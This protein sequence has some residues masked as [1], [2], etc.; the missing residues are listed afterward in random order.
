MVHAGR[1]H[2]TMLT[3]LKKPRTQCL[4]FPVGDEPLG[5]KTLGMRLDLE[6]VSWCMVAYCKLR[7]IFLDSPGINQNTSPQRQ[8]AKLTCFRT[9]TPIKILWFGKLKVPAFTARFYS[10]SRFSYLAIFCSSVSKKSVNIESLRLKNFTKWSNPIP[11]FESVCT[12]ASGK[13]PIPVCKS[14]FPTPKRG[15]SQLPF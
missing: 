1:R 4:Y 9:L 14:H 15:K 7:P 5:T 2:F 12:I 11:I 13:I 6:L 10:S 3:D 8:L